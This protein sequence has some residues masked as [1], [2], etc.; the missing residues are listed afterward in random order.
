MNRGFRGFTDFADP[1]G[2]QLDHRG[3]QR[4]R[5]IGNRTGNRNERMN[6]GFDGLTD[7]A[8]TQERCAR[9][10]QL[11]QD[12]RLIRQSAQSVESVLLFALVIETCRAAG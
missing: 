10:R 3:M 11:L 9:D 1:L 4:F 2:R 5:E 6:G 8:E 12:R 7:F